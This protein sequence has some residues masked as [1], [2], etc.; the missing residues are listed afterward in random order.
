MLHLRHSNEKP[1]PS[2]SATMLLLSVREASAHGHVSSMS[3][4]III[5][6][7]IRLSLYI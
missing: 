7:I 6:I 5:I 2:L 4:M 1:W 3:T